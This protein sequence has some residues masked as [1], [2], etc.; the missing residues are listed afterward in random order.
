MLSPADRVLVERVLRVCALGALAWL[1]IGAFRERPTPGAVTVSADVAIASLDRWVRRAPAET[2]GLRLGQVPSV[3]TRDYLRALLANGTALAWSNESI[4]SIML[5]AEPLADPAG[6]AIARIAATG[7]SSVVLGDS[8]GT[9][10]SIESVGSGATVRLPAIAGGLMARTGGTVA[11]LTV[12]RYQGDRSAVLLGMAGWESKFVQRALEERGWRVE[13]RLAIA[14]R[15]ATVQGTPLPLDTARHA[16]VIALDSVAGAH[17]QEIRRFVESGGGLVLGE[18]A[19]SALRALAPGGRGALV[20][21]AP[22]VAGS[23]RARLDFQRLDPLR[24]G[25]AALE[26]RRDDVAVAAWRVGRGRVVQSG[27]RDTWRWRMEGGESAVAEHRAWWSGLVAAAAYRPLSAAGP[28]GNPA[29]L[30]ALMVQW[31]PPSPLPVSGREAV[32]WPWL[33]GLLVLAVLGEWLSRRLRGT[34]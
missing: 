17:G 5:D 18:A 19:A 33:A 23:G 14:P 1:I 32:L 27:Y 12:S 25:A 20:R 3:E 11:A 30:A 29:P 8:L 6:G 4:A 31:G 24:G 2:L 34:A 9:L 28:A 16:V 15:L 22:D 10:D 26:R 21:P 13:S 7:G